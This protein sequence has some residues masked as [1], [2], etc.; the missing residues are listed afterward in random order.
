MVG[1]DGPGP[2][3]QHIRGVAATGTH[4]VAVRNTYTI[5][6]NRENRVW[7]LK[8]LQKILLIIKSINID[9]LK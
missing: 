6:W 5:A 7:N 3:P 9:R 4:E 1:N 8:L 2:V